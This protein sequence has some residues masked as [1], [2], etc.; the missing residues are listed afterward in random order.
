MREHSVAWRSLL[1]GSP[2]GEQLARQY[3]RCE[4]LNRYAR[5]PRNRALATE[6]S[7]TRLLYVRRQGDRRGDADAA[8]PREIARPTERPMRVAL[9]DDGEGELRPDPRE[10]LEVFRRSAVEVERHAVEQAR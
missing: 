10:H 2:N 6:C 3:T 5:Y 7:A 8:H 9:A 4:K 1:C